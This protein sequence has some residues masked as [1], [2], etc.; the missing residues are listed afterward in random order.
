MTNRVA[1]PKLRRASII[2]TAKSRQVPAP[3]ASV[4]AAVCVPSSWRAPIAEFGLDRV[5][6]RFEHVERAGVAHVGDEAARP[7]VNGPARIRQLPLGEPGDVGHV[8]E[9]VGKGKVFGARVEAVDR[10]GR[11]V[12]VMR[13]VEGRNDPQALGAQALRPFEEAHRIVV[14]VMRPMDQPRLRIDLENGLVDPEI[15]AVVG[16]QHQAVAGQADRVAVAVLRR[17]DDFDPGHRAFIAK[18]RGPVS[19]GFAYG[20]S[21]AGIAPPPLA[22]V[23]THLSRLATAAPTLEGRFRGWGVAPNSKS[24]ALFALQ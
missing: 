14:G 8:L 21:I 10:G 22:T 11:P 1:T 15:M 20:R 13:Q 18:P 2:R 7:G 4:S 17:M 12:G 6:H 16:P 5:R 19:N 23:F 9:V 24:F 3:S